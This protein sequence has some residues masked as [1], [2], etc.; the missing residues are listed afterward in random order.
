MKKLNLSV[1]FLTA[2]PTKPYSVSN[3]NLYGVID[4]LRQW[5]AL[6]FG[7]KIAIGGK[8]PKNMALTKTQ[9]IEIITAET[10]L[11]KKKSGDTVESLIE[12]IKRTLA[13]DEDVM[14]SGFGKFCVNSKG[15]RRGRNPA[16]GESMMLAPRKVV[17]F[18][19]S[20]KLRQKING[21]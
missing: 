1:K 18:K 17:T 9:I 2:Y 14:I 8:D 5:Q 19:C 15:K 21:E 7:T 13:S 4:K 12:I 20:G 3:S 16:T 11:S 10:G 6:G